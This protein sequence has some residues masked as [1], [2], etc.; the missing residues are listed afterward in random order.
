MTYLSLDR[1]GDEKIY[2]HIIYQVLRHCPTLIVGIDHAKLTCAVQELHKEL[3][4]PD[5]PHSSSS[6]CSEASLTREGVHHT[7]EVPSSHSVFRVVSPD[8][9]V[10][11][12][13]L[14]SGSGDSQKLEREESTFNL[15]EVRS[16]TFSISCCEEKCSVITD[17]E[18]HLIFHAHSEQPR[19]AGSRI[20]QDEVNG[21]KG[22]ETKNKNKRIITLNTP[23]SASEKMDGPDSLLIHVSNRG[24]ISELRD[25]EDNCQAKDRSMRS[26]C[27][28]NNFSSSPSS[29]QGEVALVVRRLSGGITN[30][31]FHVYCPIRG[32]FASSVVVRV[33]GKET[34]Q[35]ISRESELFYQL[36]FLKTMVQGQNFLIYEYL[37]GFN[38]LEFTEMPHFSTAI[39]DAMADFQVRA[40]IRAK[41]SAPHSSDELLSLSSVSLDPP[42]VED[43]NNKATY[44]PSLSLKTSDRGDVKNC[45]SSHPSLEL[46]D[47]NGILTE[48]KI[49]FG[50]ETHKIISSSMQASSR[51]CQEQNFTK[52]G[53]TKWIRQALRKETAMKV[54]S[55][56]REDFNRLADALQREC[57]WA[58]EQIALVEEKL[59][60][61][62]C[63]N[64]LLCGNLMWSNDQKKLKIIDFD[65]THRNYLL[66][67]LANHFNE[68]AGID[69]DFDT[70][71]PSDESIREFVVY[72]RQAMGCRLGVR[73]ASTSET[74]ARKDM[75]ALEVER[76]G[77]VSSSSYDPKHID[78]SSP[79]L[80]FH[81]KGE[82][83]LDRKEESLT[84]FL[85]QDLFANSSDEEEESI[86][87]DWVQNC[88][89]LSL[90][91]HLL[92][93]IW[94]LLQ[95]A[96]SGLKDVDF[97]DFSSKRFQ[98]F[99]KKKEAFKITP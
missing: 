19:M 54:K 95:E 85:H 93:A 15:S 42:N 31:L 17:G 99:L 24:M 22:V 55:D 74:E 34:E 20:T 53:L 87:S 61:G 12:S 36:L 43:D 2:L 91:S 50:M 70:Y 16:D 97:L 26:P 4:S 5:V 78:F 89:F 69:M 40:T 79:P 98:Q 65:Y 11:M 41:E 13:S 51:F 86:V 39:A 84:V 75:N 3:F 8:G 32:G 10:I 73:A 30:E 76:S 82:S 29:K 6:L 71:F 80:E 7:L 92:W 94:A 58:L 62:V 57:V 28:C 52:T 46:R 66:F 96:C 25:T 38:P 60:E 77:L 44:T 35:F 83:S 67:D 9:A 72:Y 49:P 45:F 63:H 14:P 27:S 37:V 88:K 81:E 1:I 18:V 64:D 68:Y 21:V 56:K 47:D 59:I 90:C 48:K 33:F 23:G